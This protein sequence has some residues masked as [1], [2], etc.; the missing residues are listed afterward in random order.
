MTGRL[1]PEAAEHD[2]RGDHPQDE[3]GD[4]PEDQSNDSQGSH[5]CQALPGHRALHAVRHRRLRQEERPE[6]A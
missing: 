1:D 2:R 3:P 5:D 4:S 6:A